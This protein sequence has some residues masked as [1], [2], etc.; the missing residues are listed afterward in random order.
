MTIKPQGRPH[1]KR[2]YKRR[3]Y[4]Q[5][6]TCHYTTCPWCGSE[7]AVGSRLGTVCHACGMGTDH[8]PVLCYV[9]E[10]WAYFTSQ[11]L[12][13]QWGD[14]WDVVPYEHNSR[15][16]YRYCP[17]IHK[18]KKPWAII[19]VAWHGELY[20]QTWWYDNSPYSVRD[21]NSGKVPWL[22][23]RFATIHAGVSLSRFI[24]LVRVSGG[25]VYRRL[26]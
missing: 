15:P 18:D 17:G 22:E 24:D 3:Q 26:I 11:S 19:R 23:G 10:S 20:D 12:E 13:E 6:T 7:K 14:N 25:E 9:E 5:L 21:I 4:E 16:P 8:E 1:R 2:G